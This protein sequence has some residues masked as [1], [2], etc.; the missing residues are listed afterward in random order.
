MK[1]GTPAEQT[2]QW[3]IFAKL[4]EAFSAHIGAS[5]DQL[6]VETKERRSGPDGEPLD[7]AFNEQRA[8]VSQKPEGV[9]EIAAGSTHLVEIEVF[10]D[11]C[12]PWKKGSKLASEVAEAG[13]PI[14][15]V[16]V[17]VDEQVRGKQPL[18]L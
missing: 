17:T 12:W 8:V 15:P 18:K 16:T 14:E 1:R 7:K 6:L 10:N 5:K 13:C 3:E 11:T 2:E 9:I 4:V